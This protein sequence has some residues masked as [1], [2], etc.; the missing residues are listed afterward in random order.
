MK[1]IVIE[2]IEIDP[3]LGG[4]LD[5]VL[6][7]KGDLLFENRLQYNRCSTVGLQIIDALDRIR[8]T[9]AAGDNRVLERHSEILG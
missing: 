1:I 2:L 5:D 8:Q 7:F 3:L 9:R 6:I 4:F